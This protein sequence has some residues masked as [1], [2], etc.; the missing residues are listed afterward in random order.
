MAEKLADILNCDIMDIND[1]SSKKLSELDLLKDYFL[2]TKCDLKLSKTDLDKYDLIIFGYPIWIFNKLHPLFKVLKCNID[3]L[4]LKYAKF[5]SYAF[6]SWNFP[7]ISQHKNNFIDSL[8]MKS[9]LHGY[10][11]EAIEELTKWCKR[12]LTKIT[13]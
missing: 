11:Q 5:T 13:K 7:G 4:N 8:K 6:Y 10:E 12:I 3:S 2:K 9:P 1:V